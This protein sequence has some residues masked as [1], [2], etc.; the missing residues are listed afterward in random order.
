MLF[1]SIQDWTADFNSAA[2]TGL[3]PNTTYYVNVQVKDAAGNLAVMSTRAN[4]AKA[5]LGWRDAMQVVRQLEAS[6]L[7][8]LDGLAPGA[9]VPPTFTVSG[10]A[11][12]RSAPSGTG[13]DAVH[14]WALPATGAAPMFIGV[15]SVG[16]RRDD[17]A[18][19]LGA[20]FAGSGFQM[21]VSELAPGDYALVIAVHSSVS[22]TFNQ[23]RT[24]NITIASSWPK[25]SVDGPLG[26]STI[27]GPFTVSGWALDRAAFTGCGIDEIHVWAFPID[28]GSPVFAGMAAAGQ[29]RPD[30]GKIFGRQFDSCGYALNVATLPAGTYDVAVYPHGAVSGTFNQMRAVRVTI[31]DK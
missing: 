17:V 3:T 1:R 11:I 4:Q 2:I 9:A 31:V 29:S 13:V 7:D 10:W 27:S 14:V 5:D 25:M 26:G 12:D 19:L 23:S 18:A 16:A 28:G 30:V 24:V 20:Q 15:A 21:P 8:T 6:G 22:G